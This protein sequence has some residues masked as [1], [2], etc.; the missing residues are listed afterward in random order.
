MADPD[1]MTRLGLEVLDLAEYRVLALTA[2]VLYFLFSLIKLAR[3]KAWPDAKE[4]IRGIFAIL[5]IFGAVTVCCVFLLTKPP[6]IEKLSDDSRGVV[7]VICL[8]SLSAMAITEIRAVF[9]AKKPPAGTA[10][11]IVTPT[12]T[13]TGAPAPPAAP[14][15]P[16]SPMPAGQH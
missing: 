16:A 4:S 5:S 15:A 7:G 6:A 2:I 10:D 14:G 1:R 3:Q 12:V 8:V 9:I 11:P 13:P